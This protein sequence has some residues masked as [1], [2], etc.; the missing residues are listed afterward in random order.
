M[1]SSIATDLALQAA[2]L[3]GTWSTDVPTQLSVLDDGAAA[4]LAGDAGLAGQPLPLEIA[5]RRTHPDD[6]DWVFTHIR[7]M[8]STGGPFAAEFRVETTTNDV[9]WVLTLGS[10]AP[11]QDGTMQGRGCYIDTTG[12]HRKILRQSRRSRT[13]GRKEL[14]RDDPLI[15]ASDRYIEAHAEIVRTGNSAL[16]QASEMVLWLLGRAIAQRTHL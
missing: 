7:R 14:D 15:I 6:R 10:L 3:I 4:L 12:T 11:G 8:R 13:T 1:L 5:L 16:R 9:R 2:G